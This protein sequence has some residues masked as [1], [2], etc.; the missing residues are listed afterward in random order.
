MCGIC[1]S[2]CYG[3][4]DRHLKV[5]SGEHIGT[6]PMTFRKVK[7]SKKHA[8]R[9]CFLIC[10]NIPSFHDFTILADR[11]HK[12]VLEIKEKLLIKYDRPAL[13][14][15]IS[16]VKPFFIL[17]TI[18]ILKV[19]IIPQYCFIILFDMF[20]TVSYGSYDTFWNRSIK[21][22]FINVKWFQGNKCSITLETLENK[23]KKLIWQNSSHLC[24]IPFKQWLFFTNIQVWCLALKAFVKVT[25]LILKVV[26]TTFLVVSFVTL[27][28]STCEARKNSFY[29]TS[30]DCFILEIIKF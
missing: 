21:I 26:S 27:K 8:I 18:R 22:S 6:S 16:S 4:T 29:F 30:K 23:L 17:T 7:S 25:F 15:N 24:T 12:Y 28:E 11:H 3:E 20:V 13:N 14:K 2:S 5:R 10:N 9:D 19:F 1:N